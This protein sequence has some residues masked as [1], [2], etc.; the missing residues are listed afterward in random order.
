MANTLKHKQSSVAGK[1]PTTTDLALG[2]LAINTTDG[3]VYMKKNVSGTESIVEVTAGGG[4]SSVTLS[5]NISLYINQSTTLTITNYNVFSTYS[6]AVSAGSVSRTGDSISFTAPASAQT[7]TLTVTMDGADYAFEIVIQAA[8][9]ATPTNSSPANG[10]TNQDGSVTLTASA[11]S[12][13]GLSDTHASSDW[14]LATDS[15]FSTVVQ[16]Q[17]ASSSNKTTWTVT[18]LS[19]SQ[20][21]YWRVRYTGAANGT[22]SWSSATSFST[23]AS[24]GGLIGAQ[25][26][27]GFGVGEYPTT[28][29]S[30]FTA[31]SG[32]TDPANANYG[33]YQYSDGSVMVFVPK[34]YYR[35]GHASSPRYATYGANAIDVVG[36]E[37]YANEAAAN[38]A[39]YAMHRAFYDGGAE[40]SGFFIDK[41]LASKNGNSC[42]SIQNGNPISLTTNASYNPSN[43][44]TGCT[45]ILA[46]AVV[47]ARSRAAG[48]FNVASVF[49]VDA[50][51][52]L[53]LA[54]A[55]AST[56]TTYC[57]WYDATNNFPKGCNNGSLA[58]TNDAT[59]TF[60]NATPGVDTKPLTGSA[61]NLAKTTHN[62]QSCGVTDVNGALWQVMLGLTQAGS[63]ATDTTQITTGDAYLLKRSVALASLTG[64]F[65]GS[66]DAW[67][68]AGNLATN[69]DAISGF[70]PWTSTTGWEY[71][72]NGSSAVFSG[73]TSGT[74]YLRS[75]AGIGITTGMSASGTSQFGNDGSY[76]YGRTNLFP[77]ASGR[78]GGA[79]GAGVFCRNWGYGRSTDVNIVGFRASAYG[80]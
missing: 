5:G 64:G 18:G 6:V 39:G 62:G 26:G 48:T 45:G 75:C 28:L 31:L 61:S 51:A 67:G 66:T 4:G 69:Y 60:S 1:A 30:G 54:H 11:F 19:T 36:I 21:Y 24:F 8:G 37:A 38:T 55:Q 63:S 20:T 34:F 2:E 71:F 78:W 25:G 40:K 58:D 50:L 7:V 52:K 15:G 73:A 80:S 10:A 33:N 77:V 72:G 27:Q 49:M 35:I 14:Q 57:A 42:K 3:K 74:D 76:R 68:T 43:G 70:L 46:D 53:S 12:W 17:T 29:P 47:L 16:S 56:T 79:A 32:A 44:M 41:Y 59:V 23:K 22:S 13:V 65:G 9:V